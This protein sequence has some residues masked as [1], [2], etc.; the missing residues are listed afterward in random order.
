[1][2]VGD[3]GPGHCHQVGLSLGYNPF[4]LHGVR[5]STCNQDGETAVPLH[6][7]RV[8]HPQARLEPHRRHRLRLPHHVLGRCSRDAQVVH[9]PRGLENFEDLQLVR[10]T[11]PALGPFV[12]SPYPDPDHEVLSD[13]LSRRFYDLQREAQPVLQ[14]AAVCVGALVGERR[15]ELLRQVPRPDHDLHPVE[16][17]LLQPTRGLPIS[18]SLRPL[19]SSISMA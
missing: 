15:K 11:Q 5:D 2:R 12:L 13:P 8:V 10:P 7:G 4:S 19:I 18:L 16:A 9:L 1:M 14:R 3:H 17:T 6:L